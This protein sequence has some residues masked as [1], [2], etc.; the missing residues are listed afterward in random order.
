[1]DL[2]NVLTIL[3][4]IGGFAAAWT[5]I[6]S[7][8]ASVRTDVDNL[9]SQLTD[10]KHQIQELE[11]EVKE[12]QR[13]LVTSI[14]QISKTSHKALTEVEKISAHVADLKSYMATVLERHERKMEQYDNNIQKF[15][16]T[17]ELPKKKDK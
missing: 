15:Y 10:S 4:M 11:T 1:M 14:N 17:Y 5:R 7:F 8:A 6:N 9:K 13:Q 2:Q 3:V 12:I 16:E